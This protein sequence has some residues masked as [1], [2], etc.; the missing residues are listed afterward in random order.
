[1][2]HAPARGDVRRPTLGQEEVPKPGW[3]PYLSCSFG[4][5]LP[6]LAML[7]LTLCHLLTPDCRDPTPDPH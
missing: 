6:T 4:L 1:M 7:A 5:Q 3:T 2:G